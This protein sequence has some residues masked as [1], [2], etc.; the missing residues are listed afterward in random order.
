[1]RIN[2]LT[3]VLSWYYVFLVPLSLIQESIHMLSPGTTTQ[4]RKLF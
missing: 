2:E 4:I 1:M 3:E